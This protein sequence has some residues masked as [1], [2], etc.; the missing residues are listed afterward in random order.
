MVLASACIF[1]ISLASKSNPRDAQP[2][3]SMPSLIAEPE[4][5]IS[6]PVTPSGL[7]VEVDNPSVSSTSA[8]VDDPV[9]ASQ[10]VGAGASSGSSSSAS[11][12]G[13]VV[14]SGGGEPGFS[15]GGLAATPCGFMSVVVSAP[16]TPS[17]GGGLPVIVPP[18]GSGME[19]NNSS[20]ATHEPAGAPAVPMRPN[21]S[22]T[23][24]PLVELYDYETVGKGIH[25]QEPV[26]VDPVE[27][28]WDKKHFV[29]SNADSLESVLVPRGMVQD[30]VERIAVD[31]EKT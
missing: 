20:S 9:P 19:V 30:R 17:G 14:S 13:L 10:D 6:I 5:T 3:T 26:Y 28:S 8:E 27:F 1:A 29:L 23:C 4:T 2:A 25:R 7:E 12:G 24:L 22:F 31:I 11:N 16:A 21:S 15:G 18:S